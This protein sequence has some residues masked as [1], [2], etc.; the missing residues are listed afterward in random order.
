M[1]L[2]VQSQVILIASSKYRLKLRDFLYFPKQPA[3]TAQVPL[4][5]MLPGLS[6]FKEVKYQCPW[7][8]MCPALPARPHGTMWTSGWDCFLR[9]GLEM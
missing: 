6:F 2:Y 9:Q 8:S 4:K 3:H 5:A 1:V 7:D